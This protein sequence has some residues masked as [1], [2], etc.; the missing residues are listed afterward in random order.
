MKRLNL[1]AI[2]VVLLIVYSVV[3]LYCSSRLSLSYDE[4]AFSDYGATLLK[5]IGA[6]DVRK[7]DSK[8]P[9]TALHMLPRA[10]EQLLNPSLSK[11][12]NEQDIRRGRWATLAATMALAW[13]VYLWARRLYGQWPAILSITMF[14][15][16]PNFLAHGILVSSDIF[17][18]LFT[19]LAAYHAWKFCKAGS[20]YDFLIGSVSV[21]LGL[22]SKFSMV[23]LVVI[24]PMLI[25]VSFLFQK[26]RTAWTAK[27]AI[28]YLSAYLLIIWVILSAAHL[29]YGMFLPF[30]EYAFQ[31]ALMQRLQL[32]LP[33]LPVPLPS[34][35]IQSLDIVLYYDHLGGGLPGSING[36]TYLLGEQAVHGFWYYYL[37][38]MWFKLPIATWMISILAIIFFFRNRSKNI[39]AFF[40]DEFFLF[41]PVFYYLVYMSFFYSTQIGI[42][43]VLMVLP[44]LFVFSGSLLQKGR[45]VF[46]RYFLYGCLVFQSIS[47]GTY[48][49]HFLPYT[50][51][52]IIDKKKAYQKLADTNICYGEGDQYLQAYLSK[53]PEALYLPERIT[54]GTVVMEVNEMLDLNSA[55]IGKYSWVRK[56][57]PV[58]HIHSQYLIFHVS[59]AAKDSLIFQKQ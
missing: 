28:T 38:A 53:H 15:L 30:R 39:S 49:P 23:H 32:M 37:V 56:L 35:Y 50:N 9:I 31:S 46:L 8:L 16:C 10:V 5:G 34:S 26:V 20:K 25:L 7:Y 27:K 17:A 13:M 29:F 59:Q 54:T 19:F 4:S 52:W 44:L 57:E 12:N 55:T 45:P 43:H 11:L 21:G 33:A 2:P 58:G 3:Q 36:A 18:C 14:L 48:F 51:E 47:V 1:H 24:Y 22:I 41:L 42:R 40:R 6:K